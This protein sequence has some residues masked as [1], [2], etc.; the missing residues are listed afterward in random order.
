MS[1]G[2]LCCSISPVWAAEVPD[3][4][5]P[6]VDSVVLV[7][8]DTLRA[9]HVGAYGGKAVTPTLD[10]LAEQG[11]LLEQASTSVPSTGPAHVSLMSGLYPWR[12][13]A[14]AN[15][16]P[17]DPE[18][19]T[20]AQV[21]SKRGLE[22][23]AFV[24]SYVVHPRFGFDR[25]FDTY[26]FEPTKG[27]QWRGK[28]RDRFWS[29]GEATVTAAADWIAAHADVPFFVW[30]HLFDPH[31]PYLPPRGFALSPTKHVDIF[32]KAVPK[33]VRDMNHLAQLNRQYR[34]EVGYADAQLGRLIGE[35]SRLKL[36]ERT[37]VIV[38]SD[39]GEGLG[40]HGLLEHGQNV[41]DEL[42]RVPLIFRAVGL[43][44]GRRLAGP[45]QLEDLMPT[46][47]ALVGV[48]SETGSY[49]VDG[50]DLLP[51]LRG[52]TETSP[53][54]W[55]LGR[56]RPYPGRPDL[57]FARRWPEK[58]IGTAAGSGDAAAAYGKV[59][60]L[61][62]D[63]G[64]RAGRSGKLAPEALRSALR[65]GDSRDARTIPDPDPQVRRALEALGYVD[66]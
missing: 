24:S 43:P 15:A 20:L 52:A 62:S 54:S 56:R 61:D 5:L 65:R 51:W 6:G 59:Y 64:E 47:L 38:T 66:P 32:G 11:V 48:D 57:F 41:F 17:L 21:L 44:A 7:T 16:V 55:T 4:S 63:P 60:A 12:H 14:L 2:M 26:Y 25:G 29:R 33:G 53:R 35:L 13:G 3:R 22:T 27:Y 28:H 46:I 37:A 40:D 36:T 18:L 23:G 9:D 1:I 10:R 19:V 42:V 45:A 30:V 34:G 8:I 31:T 50:V 39:H 49:G 58:W